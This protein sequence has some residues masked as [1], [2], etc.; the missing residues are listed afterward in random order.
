MAFDYPK[1]YFYERNGW[2]YREDINLK[3]EDVL[4]MSFTDFGKWVDYFR[5]TAIEQWDKTDAP[6]R[7]GMD[8]ASII[9]NFSK[10][11]AFKVHEFAEKD[12][13]GDDVIFNFN[14]FAT[15][16]NQ[17]F[18]AMYKTGIGGSA[19]DKPKP[20]IYDVFVND[21]Y[22]QEFIKQMRRLTRQDGMYRFTKTVHL[23]NSNY[24]N[25]HIQ[26]GKEWI[27]KWAA[28]DTLA[29]HDFCLSQADSKV[30]SPEITAEEIKELWREGK[31]RYENI[32]SLK[33]ADWGDNIDNLTDLPKQPIQI[34]I[35][36]LG[37]TIFP[38]A[39]AA[40]RIGMG[41]QAVVNFPPLTAKFL[42]QKFTQ[43]IKDQDIINIYDPSAGWG[44]R[45]LGAMSVD[46]RNIHYIGNDPNTEN[47]LDEIGKT[48]YEYLAEFFNN[49]VPGAAN[50]FWGHRNTYELFTTGSEIIAEE[51]RFQKYK[52][53]LDFVFTS[54][55]YFDRERYSDDD[56]QSFKKFN[57]YESWRD[58]FLRPTL[59]TAYEYLRNDRYICWN[60]ADIKVGKD[61]WWTL[62]QD[63]IDILT[64]LGC[65]YKGK[66]KMTMS[67]MTGVDLSGVKNSMQIDGTY[68][69]YE[70]IFVF[71]K[72]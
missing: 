14:K 58:G 66:I 19:Y 4:K 67:P 26:S 69:K 27:E 35:Y 48:R 41:T 61:K 43:H 60:I 17:F 13:L 15:P 9:E 68:Y 57:N 33:T 18:P 70:P 36:P 49:K 30:P 34:K 24:H 55:P 63:S 2:I 8:E 72:P 6:P 12:D 65:E 62:E 28:G 16:V 59:T 51:E 46:D 40:F 53:K 39:T 50:L 56:S 3:Y 47:Y 38:E 29:G 25:S 31:L 44:G 20:S 23:D 32:S 10:L 52:G 5:K 22:L 37:Q 45:I 42:Y 7:I 11:Q 54:P 21:D 71:Y 1:K 64:E